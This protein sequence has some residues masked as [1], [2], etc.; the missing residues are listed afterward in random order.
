MD[1][2]TTRICRPSRIVAL[3]LIA[4]AMLSLAYLHHRPSASTVPLPSGAEAGELTLEP[5]EYATDSG[6]YAADWPITLDSWLAAAQGDTRG[7]WFQSL[8]ADLRDLIDLQKPV[9]A[10][11]SWPLERLVGLHSRPI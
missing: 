10:F 8:F 7:F 4:L 9:R 11:L 1:T 2:H 3:M 6:S 5:C